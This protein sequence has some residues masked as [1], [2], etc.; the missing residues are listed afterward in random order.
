EFRE[1]AFAAKR[2]VPAEPVLK[3]PAGDRA[4]ALEIRIAEATGYTDYALSFADAQGV[5]LGPAVVIQKDTF[6]R[7][8]M[9]M[10]L[11]RLQPGDYFLTLYGVEQEKKTFLV[12]RRFRVQTRGPRHGLVRG[13]A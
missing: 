10:D 12:R 13:G 1:L 11:E 3:R 5:A 7:F 8:K 4:L 2:G 9:E 6:G